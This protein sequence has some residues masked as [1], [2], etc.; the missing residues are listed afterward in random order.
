MIDWDWKR[1]YLEEH[2][3]CEV[4]GKRPSVDIDHAIFLRHERY[5]KYVNQPWNF[6][7]ACEICNRG[8]KADQYGERMKALERK[9]ALH[10]VTYIRERLDEFPEGKKKGRDW[11][12]ADLKLRELED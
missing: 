12:E 9:V 8:K 6:Q 11:Q 3:W 5:K 10:G 7:A 2:F 1:T 4:C